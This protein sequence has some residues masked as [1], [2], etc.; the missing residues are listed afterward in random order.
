[1]SGNNTTLGGGGLHH[2]AIRTQDLDASVKF[3]TEV[4]GMKSVV[5][6]KPDE[7][8]FVQLDAGD[9]SIVELMQDDKQVEPAAERNVHWHY[10]LRTTRIE[11][12]MAAVEAAG[13]EITVPVKAVTLENTA[14]DPPSPLPVK[15]AFFIGPSGEVVEL[16]QN[17]PA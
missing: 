17:E 5:A 11:E 13:M 12:V 14:T 9:G 1:M 10:A 16:F 2:V 7:R 8:S 3:Y 4:L 15:V 6:F